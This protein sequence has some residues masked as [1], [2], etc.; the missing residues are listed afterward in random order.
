MMERIGPYE[1]LTKIGS[2]GMGAV[3]SARHS[4]TGATVALKVMRLDLADDVSFVKRFRREAATASSI[5]SS[6][7]VGVHE[8]GIDG[9]TPYI[10][11]ELVEGESLAALM[12]R[13]G[14]LPVAQ[15][16]NIASQVA[17]GLEAA[18]LKGV[19]HRDISP[20]NILINDQGVAK[21]ADF[22][23]ARFQS[24]GTLTQTGVFIG[25]PS[26]SAPETI[27]G[28]SDIRSDIYSLGVVLFEM[29]AGQPPFAGATPLA[30]IKMHQEQAPPLLADMGLKVSAS[31]EEVLGRCLTKEPA[32]RFQTPAEMS[33]ALAAAA[34]AI[35]GSETAAS[36]VI[37][38]AT[39]SGSS[40]AAVPVGGDGAPPSQPP[41]SMRWGNLRQ[42]H[43]FALGAAALVVMVAVVLA[44][45]F[46]GS[47][48][49]NNGRGAAALGPS[50]SASSGGYWA[51]A[52]WKRD[53]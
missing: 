22:G 38:Q 24:G 39:G 18:H 34:R 49:D 16:L 45:V 41:T 12:R 17:H 37:N 25:K 42:P 9:D 47:G 46:G 51:T 7:V 19:T 44:V 43:Y 27:D 30:T 5:D 10:A 15:A 21:I 28:G 14:P 6:N 36:A 13:S 23:I 26:Y 1:I 50:S 53:V 3:Y 2:G 40:K 31:M 8:A 52:G 33:A 35:A 29:L 11:M 20:Q 32:D 48:G 4:Q